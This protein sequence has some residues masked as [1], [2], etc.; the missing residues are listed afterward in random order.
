[1]TK[2]TRG[3]VAQSSPTAV[4]HMEG[5]RGV[6]GHVFDVDVVGAVD[7][8]LAEISSLFARFGNNALIGGRRKLDVDESR[9]GD[10]D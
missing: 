8:A 1:M 7:H 6:G 5:T 10:I 4:A 3:R 9:A 2:H